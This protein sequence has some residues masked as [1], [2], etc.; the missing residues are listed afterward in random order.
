MKYQMFVHV[1]SGKDQDG[2]RHREST[3]KKRS[4]LVLLLHPF[5]LRNIRESKKVV[6]YCCTSFSTMLVFFFQGLQNC[7]SYFFVSHLNPVK[8]SPLVMTFIMV[9]EITPDYEKCSSTNVT[10][11]DYCATG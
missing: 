7:M 11:L 3:S 4:R 5:A 9:F 2:E 6:W 8:V 1:N 10:V